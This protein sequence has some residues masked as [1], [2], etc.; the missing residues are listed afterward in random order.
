M[1][2]ACGTVPETGVGYAVPMAES[3]PA[4]A[5]ER[6]EAILANLDAALAPVLDKLPEGSNTAV[7]F[8]I[9]EEA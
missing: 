8:R 4:D 3:I 2:V 9:P 7:V 5:R 1:T 6:A